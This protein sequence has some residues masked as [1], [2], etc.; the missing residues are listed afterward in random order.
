MQDEHFEDLYDEHALEHTRFSKLP[1]RSST[2]TVRGWLRD[3]LGM[4]KRPGN[5][6]VSL[7]DHGA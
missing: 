3:P 5:D 6:T 7:L 2:F 4:P 1:A